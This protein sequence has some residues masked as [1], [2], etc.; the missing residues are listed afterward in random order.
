MIHQYP[1]NKVC[2]ANM[3]PTR[4]LAAPGGPHIGPMNLASRVYTNHK[5]WLYVIL[6]CC[7][8]STNWFYPN[9]LIIVGFG[10][11]LRLPLWIWN[12]FPWYKYRYFIHILRIS[13]ENKRHQLNQCPEGTFSD[14]D[15]LWY[16]HGHVITPFINCRMKLVMH[17]QTSKVQLSMPGLKLIGVFIRSPAE[18]YSWTNASIFDWK[19]SF[20]FLVKH[21]KRNKFT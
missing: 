4:V 10:S 3:G 1:D 12:N 20:L 18:I 17:S 2:V 21:T 6:F 13:Y 8:V 19:L 15:Q 14:M 16:Q 11:T 9:P 7:G 5:H